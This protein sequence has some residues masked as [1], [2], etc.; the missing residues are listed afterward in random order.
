MQGEKAAA[1]KTGAE[2]SNAQPATSVAPEGPA[3]AAPA[4]DV[5]SEQK[6]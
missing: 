5:F 1:P 2:D 6:A 3:S 4:L